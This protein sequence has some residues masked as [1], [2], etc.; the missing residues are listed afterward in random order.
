[1]NNALLRAD[2]IALGRGRETARL[3]RADRR[4]R[5]GRLRRAAE[6]VRA[7]E[8]DDRGGRRRRP[9]R[10]PARRREEVRPPRRQGARADARSSCARCTR[11]GSRPT[12]LGVPTVLVARTDALS[13]TLL[14]SD[15][16]PRDAEFLTGERTRRGLLP[17]PRRARA[18]DRPRRS[19]T[20]R[21]PTCSGSRPRRPTSTR[22]ASSRRRSTSSS[23]ASCS[24]TTARR[25]STGSAHLDDAADRALPGRARRARLPLPVHHARR[26]PRAQRVD[27]RARAGLR[28]TRA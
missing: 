7:D 11:R 18:G 4:R 3:A 20:R 6:R 21:T 26:L 1:M 24:P 14:T 23:R 9:L 16:D 22:R 5:R 12:S 15:V 8:G 2:Q 10:G 17:R 28:A 27:V 19:P 13:A 25:R